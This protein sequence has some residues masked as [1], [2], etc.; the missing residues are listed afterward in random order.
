[1]FKMSTRTLTPPPEVLKFNS[2][3]LPVTSK[4]KNMEKEFYLFYSLVRRRARSKY[5]LGHYVARV[6]DSKGA[7]KDEFSRKNFGD[8]CYNCADTHSSTKGLMNVPTGTRK[9]VGGI[10]NVKREIQKLDSKV[11]S[12]DKF[13]RN[14]NMVRERVCTITELEHRVLSNEELNTLLD[15]KKDLARGFLVGKSAANTHSSGKSAR[16]DNKQNVLSKLDFADT[17]SRVKSLGSDVTNC[18]ARI[19]S[20]L[21]GRFKD[22][23]LSSINIEKPS[24][25]EKVNN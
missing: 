21:E 10:E 8:I 19:T 15:K 7:I 6:L 9:E 18:G 14:Y 1:M 25:E 13:S 20:K 22:K 4:G 17:H 23:E 24:S 3:T 2:S 12:E 11:A 16:V 5:D